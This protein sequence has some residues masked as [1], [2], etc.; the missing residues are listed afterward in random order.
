MA[1]KAY[2]GEYAAGGGLQ[3][4]AAFLAMRDQALHASLGFE[5]GDAEMRLDVTRQRRPMA[6][7]HILV[8][9]I[10]AGGGIVCAIVSREAA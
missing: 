7:R 1:T 9:S 2:F 6:L 3:L 10:S 8:N 5:S 4:A